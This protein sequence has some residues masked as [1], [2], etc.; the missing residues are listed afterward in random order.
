MTLFQAASHMSFFLL[1]YYGQQISKFHLVQILWTAI[2]TTQYFFMFFD[3][4]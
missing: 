4:K 1:F 3:S 2:I